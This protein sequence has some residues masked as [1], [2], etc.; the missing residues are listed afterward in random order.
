MDLNQSAQELI[1]KHGKRISHLSG[2]IGATARTHYKQG[3]AD[4]L[5]LLQHQ[6]VD[7]EMLRQLN[8]VSAPLAVQPAHAAQEGN[9]L[10][11]PGRDEA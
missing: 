10:G 8:S 5:N 2:L 11:V 7:E 6:A 4:L 1:D 9:P 3:V